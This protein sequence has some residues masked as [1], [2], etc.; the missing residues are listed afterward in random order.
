MLR[1][2]RNVSA[3]AILLVALTATPGL[4]GEDG[5][6]EYCKGRSEPTC[7]QPKNCEEYAGCWEPALGKGCEECNNQVSKC[8]GTPC[9]PPLAHKLRAICKVGGPPE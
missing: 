7:V 4:T 2:I 6:P 3:F 5:C 8:V 1:V 9:A